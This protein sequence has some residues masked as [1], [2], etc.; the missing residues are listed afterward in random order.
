M[1]RVFERRATTGRVASAASALK[2]NCLRSSLSLQL[3]VAPTGCSKGPRGS[4]RVFEVFVFTARSLAGLFQHSFD[5]FFVGST[6]IDTH[7]QKQKKYLAHMVAPTECSNMPC[8]CPCGCSNGSSLSDQPICLKPSAKREVSTTPKLVASLYQFAPSVH[9]VWWP[10][11][12]FER[13]VASL[14]ARLRSPRTPRYHPC[15]NI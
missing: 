9:T 1:W 7:K 8:G 6:K 14:L 10:L 2:N 13:L 3:V 4:L 15:Q 11:R 12:V 5:I